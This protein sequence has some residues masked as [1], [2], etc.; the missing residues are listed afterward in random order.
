MSELVATVIGGGLALAGGF[1]SSQ[2]TAVRDRKSRAREERV[3]TYVDLLGHLESL[4][5]WRRSVARRFGPMSDD[6]AS[7]VFRESAGPEASSVAEKLRREVEQELAT[8]SASW[9]KM[10]PLGG[11]PAIAAVRS[12]LLN[13]QSIPG[14]IQR[15]ET[16]QEEEPRALALALT[17]LDLGNLGVVARVLRD[18]LD[19]VWISEVHDRGHRRWWHFWWRRP[20]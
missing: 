1:L 10:Q 15:W 2:T 8:L 3:Q 12:S 5:E 14:L 20:T 13:V 6:P 16:G 9:T 7:R 19:Q 11:T 18:D 4:D 17:N